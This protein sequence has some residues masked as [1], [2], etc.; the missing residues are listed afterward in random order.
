MT[1]NMGSLPMMVVSRTRMLGGRRTEQ[2]YKAGVALG[3]VLAI[4]VRIDWFIVQIVFC[5]AFLPPCML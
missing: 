2:T 4:R 1:K 5:R 3:S